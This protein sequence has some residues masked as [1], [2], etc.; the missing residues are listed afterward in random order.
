M[1]FFKTTIIAGFL[2]L[3]APALAHTGI[4][5][6]SP[7]NEQILEAAPKQLSL[8]FNAPVRLMK[9]TLTDSERKD[10][11][12]GFKPSSVANTSFNVAIPKMPVGEYL[13]SW[14][15]MAKDGHKMTGDFSFIVQGK[16]TDH[17]H[18]DSE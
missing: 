3:S 14:V 16:G 2:A 17:E 12:I 4:K 18:G 10:L 7:S 5:S 15:S 9:V 13:V 11:K 1:K 8:N 6:T